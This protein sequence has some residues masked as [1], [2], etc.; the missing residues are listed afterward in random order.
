[1]GR[2]V[3]DKLEAIRE[4]MRAQNTEAHVCNVLD[5][6]A[7]TLNVRGGDVLNTPVVMSYLIVTLD[8]AVWFVDEGKVDAQLRAALEG[9]GVEIR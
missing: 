1:M 6:I 3:R 5:E 4:V 9:A 2:S 7:W 8:G